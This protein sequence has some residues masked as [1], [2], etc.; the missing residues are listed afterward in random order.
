M[1]VI[2][3]ATQRREKGGSEKGE[4]L[5]D[6][7]RTLVSRSPSGWRNFCFTFTFC[8]HNKSLPNSL[9]VFLPLN[10]LSHSE[11]EPVPLDSNYHTLKNTDLW[12][13]AKGY[14]IPK[15]QNISVFVLELLPV[16]YLSGSVWEVPALL[17]VIRLAI[18][19][20]NG[21]LDSYF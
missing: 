13:G 9:T 2:S 15:A 5:Q 19:E 7:S 3:H 17:T 16:Q 14:F 20:T 21:R 6:I 10:S 4:I 18:L 11:K 1:E 12:C 8:F